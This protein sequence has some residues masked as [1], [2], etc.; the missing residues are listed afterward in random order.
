MQAAGCK[1]WCVQH[2]RLLQHQLWL[3]ITAVFIITNLQQSVDKNRPTV[4]YI[5][6]RCS[7]RDNCILRARN[8]M[9]LLMIN[10]VTEPT[11]FEIKTQQLC[12]CNMKKWNINWIYNDVTLK[13]NWHGAK[14]CKV[15][16]W[17]CLEGC[18]ENGTKVQTLCCLV[19]LPAS[20]APQ[21]KW[22]NISLLVVKLYYYTVSSS[23]II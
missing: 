20:P 13:C 21:Q 6:Q 22:W 9:H 19:P 18:W 2:C 16:P 23:V 5:I 17:K 1:Q 8:I 3:L 12:K 10:C 14:K 7:C 11:H 4:R 15:F